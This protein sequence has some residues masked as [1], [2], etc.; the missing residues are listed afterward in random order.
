MENYYAWENT[1]TL[2]GNPRHKLLL[3]L[4]QE[5]GEVCW[6]QQVLR[7]LEPLGGIQFPEE[8]RSPGFRLH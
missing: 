4:I 7:L 1:L 3:N 2:W 5:M 8:I 6:S